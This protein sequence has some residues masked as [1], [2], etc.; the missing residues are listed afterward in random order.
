MYTLINGSQKLE[1]NNS[2]YFLNYISKY[3]NEFNLFDLKSDSY[4][5]ILESINNSNSIVFAFP[6]YVDSP[7]TVTLSFLD[8]IFDNNI[9]INKN[10]YFII[11]CGFREWQH[12][13]TALNIVKSWCIKVGAKYGGSVLI[14]A[15]EVVGNKKYKL[16]SKKIYHHLRLLSNDIKNNISNEYKGTISLINNSLY[17]KIANISWNKK[18]SINNLSKKDIRVK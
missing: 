10:I 3:L 17:C 1:K 4:E 14:G 6:L 7:N 2:K 12:N 16:L 13:L 9:K 15:G 11:N 18:G 8:Y 5:K